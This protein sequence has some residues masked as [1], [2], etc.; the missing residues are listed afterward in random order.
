MNLLIL[1]LFLIPL[2]WRL[3]SN[4]KSG[5]RWAVFLM[6]AFTANPLLMTGGALPNFNLQRCI[7]I[8]LILASI[9]KNEL[10]ARYKPV[11][12][13]PLL[14]LYALSGIPSL[15]FSIDIV[16]SIKS[17]IGFTVEIIL[18]YIVISNSIDSREEAF[19]LVK[20]G[21]AGL[22]I[23]GVLAIVER[24]TGFNPVDTFLPGYVRRD[25]YENDI[26]STFPHRILLGTAMAMGWPLALASAQKGRSHRLFW[27]I[28]LFIIVIAC[29][30]SFSR[31]PWIAAVFGGIIMFFLGG[32]AIRKQSIL[33]VIL[34]SI[35]MS[36]RPGVLDTL[37]ASINDTTNPD[38][39]KGQ[40]Y[41]YRWELWSLAWN[42]ISTDPLRTA[43]GFGQGATEVMTFDAEIS[44][45]G[46]TSVLWSW[47]NHYAA[48]MLETGIIG[49]GIMIGMYGFL[50]LGL[51]RI[52][53]AIND[54]DRTIHAA[55]ITAMI[56]MFFM[57]SNVAMFAPQL[58]YLLW[59]LIASAQFL[60]LKQSED[61]LYENT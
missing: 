23:V 1:S 14:F 48:T 10:F 36:L 27:W 31:G 35:A 18:F 38:S 50:V 45:A 54:E 7:L 56:A 37:T 13:L 41:Q 26:L 42:K 24:Y 12:F 32:N 52:R 43:F 30:F 2:T 22:A 5:A 55:I 60:Q 40:T 29:Y 46:E 20:A 17:Y 28:S 53:T 59:T 25:I 21:A 15:L 44:S 33:V 16:M 47:D 34:A 49:L 57:M 61:P 3:F 6:T 51:L 58:N 19:A 9:T 8:I 4:Y 39:F 11:R